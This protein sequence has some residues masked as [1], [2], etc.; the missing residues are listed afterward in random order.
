VLAHLKDSF[1]QLPTLLYQTIGVFGWLDT[2]LP[3][4][5]CD[6]W[7]AAILIV[8][9]VAL[10]VGTTRQ[11]IVV[12]ATAVGIVVVST[13]LSSYL[14]LALGYKGQGVGVQ[15]RY[16]MPVAVWL[17][18]LGGEIVQLQRQRLRGWV[19]HSLLLGAALFA[20]L[21]QLYAWYVNERRYAVGANGPFQFLV[22]GTWS[23]PGGW[24]LWFAVAAAAAVTLIAAGAISVRSADGPAAV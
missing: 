21:F 18:L 3:T 19:A 15:G 7:V 22:P 11:R 16:L 23:P 12:V 4:A 14:S 6:L 24:P 5:V 9:G 17:P 13:I 8:T 1:H 10:L 20:A 2:P